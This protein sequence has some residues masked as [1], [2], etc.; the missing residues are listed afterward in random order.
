MYTNNQKCDEAVR[1]FCE[2]SGPL[3]EK[4]TKIFGK[5]I[6]ADIV[7]Y[8]GLCNGAGWITKI[9]EKT[10]VLLGIEKIIELDW[11]SKDDKTLVITS[12][13][14]L[15]DICSG[16][17]ALKKLSTTHLKECRQNLISL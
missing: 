8:I 10:I 9:H 13:P 4:I 3:D 2:I 7:L 16:T 12:E 17:T 6:D 11:C 5:S 1:T 15:S 14:V